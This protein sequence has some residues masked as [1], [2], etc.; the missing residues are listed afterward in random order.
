MIAKGLFG[1]WI[2]Y[3][4]PSS[5][6]VDVAVCKDWLK[7]NGIESDIT[8]ERFRDARMVLEDACEADP[9]PVAVVPQESL[10][11]IDGAD[12]GYYTHD[13][14]RILKG[15]SAHR[16][17]YDHAIKDKIQQRWSLYSPED[18]RLYDMDTLREALR[19][20][21]RHRVMV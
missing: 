3:G 4:M 19:R 20:I 10:Y 13:G 18:V 7:R 1:G 14:Y 12:S 9:Y 6:M 16:D 15:Q 17:L 21:A 8:F 5:M 2:I 11:R